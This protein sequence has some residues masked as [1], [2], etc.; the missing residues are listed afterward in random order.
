M[1]R[2]AITAAAFAAIEAALPLGTVA[3]EPKVNA[4]GDQNSHSHGEQDDAI[5]R[6]FGLQILDEEIDELTRCHCVRAR[7]IDRIPSSVAFH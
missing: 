1:I 2:I 5:E 3:F 7:P 6:P 4:K